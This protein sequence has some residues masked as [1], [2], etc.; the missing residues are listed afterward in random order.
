[1]ER[2]GPPS[3]ERGSDGFRERGKTKELLVNDRAANLD[4]AS[5]RRSAKA[6][7]EGGKGVSGDRSSAESAPGNPKARLPEGRRASRLVQPRLDLRGGRGMGR[8]GAAHP[9]ER[10]RGTRAAATG[11]LATP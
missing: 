1:V 11:G 10:H 2:A 7:P 4:R 6:S 9:G 8:T 3:E 5:L